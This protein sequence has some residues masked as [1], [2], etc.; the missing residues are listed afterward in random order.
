MNSLN[1]KFAIIGDK[2]ILK[3]SKNF[4]YISRKKANKIISQSK[5][6]IANPENL[7]SYFV[8]DC[9]SNHLIV[10]YNKFFKNYNSLNL[11][12]LTPITFN[13]TKKDINII[14]KKIK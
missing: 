9:L 6:A 5:Y 13:N 14:K 10:F 2:I 1:Y 12:N 4:G 11:K 8:Q 7:Y 3:D